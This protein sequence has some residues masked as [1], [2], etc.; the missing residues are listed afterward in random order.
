MLN[1]HLRPRREINI[2]QCDRNAAIV[3]FKELAHDLSAPDIAE[4]I[5][6][7]ERGVLDQSTLVHW[8]A[9]HR[10]AER[11]RIVAWLR[12]DAADLEEQQNKLKPWASQEWLLLREQV[13]C[14]QEYADAIERGEYMEGGE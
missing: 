12:K 4:N 1:D 3:I 9:R 5:E 6:W 8:L 11:E 13:E 10:M 7:Y 2:E 14:A